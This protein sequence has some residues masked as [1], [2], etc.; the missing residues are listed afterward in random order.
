MMVQVCLAS[1]FL[2]TAA[3]ESMDYSRSTREIV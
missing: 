3:D 2:V 1:L